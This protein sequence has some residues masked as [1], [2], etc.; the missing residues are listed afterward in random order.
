MLQTEK[1]FIEGQNVE[2]EPNVS[3][4]SEVCL[5]SQRVKQFKFQ[6][7][8]QLHYLTDFDNVVECTLTIVF[9]VSKLH[10]NEPD[11]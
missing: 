11:N 9:G 6:R 4:T 2:L 3:D 5:H 1:L 7:S 8:Q 10:Y